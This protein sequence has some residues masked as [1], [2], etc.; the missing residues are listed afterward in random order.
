MDWTMVA[1]LTALAG[2]LG[3]IFNYSVIKPMNDAIN[4]LKS[5]AEDMR[6]DIREESGKRQDMAERLAAVESSA[7]S[8]HHRIDTLEGRVNHDA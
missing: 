5:A 6:R 3:I 7:K 8:A 1:S 2:L 4:E